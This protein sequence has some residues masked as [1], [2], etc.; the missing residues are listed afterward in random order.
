MKWQLQGDWPV[1]AAVIPAGTIITD[2]IGLPMPPP[3]NAMALDEE[4]ALAMAMAY[5]ETDT[6]NG[7]HQLHFAP[8]IDRD[9]IFAQA[10]HKKRWP[11][12]M[13]TTSQSISERKDPTDAEVPT[14]A[15]EANQAQAKAHH[16][17]KARRPQR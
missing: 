10:R 13:P 9:K 15:I 6:I 8:G 1:G 7:W 17:A 16:K 2:D 12:G 4:S 11:N 5:N 14:Q 3:I